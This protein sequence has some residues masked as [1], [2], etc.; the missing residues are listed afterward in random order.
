MY[1]GMRSRWEWLSYSVARY[2]RFSIGGRGVENRTMAT[3]LY[4]CHCGQSIK[5][6]RWRL[7]KRDCVDC[8]MARSVSHNL[9]L[10]QHK[11]AAWNAWRDAM[12]DFIGREE[13]TTEEKD[14]GSEGKR[15]ERH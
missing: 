2:A 13:S 4:T 1:E 10:S 3:L 5:P 11:G 14:N 9:Q 8:A 6:S 7:G 15:A 12:L